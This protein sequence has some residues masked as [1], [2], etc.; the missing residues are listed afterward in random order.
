M[1][2]S[3]ETV[4]HLAHLARLSCKP[5]ELLRVQQ[6]LSK[7]VGFIEQLAEVDTEGVAP[8]L[9]MSEATNIWRED[10]ISGSIS[11]TEALQSSPVTSMDYFKVPT[12]IKK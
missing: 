3:Q 12:V 11:Q 10:T 5:V 6:D 8:L 2:I 9:F 7:M 4:Q 1:N